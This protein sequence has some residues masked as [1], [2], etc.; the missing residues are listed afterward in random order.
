[1]KLLRLVVSDLHVGTGVG[2]GE[3]NPSEDFFWDDRFA[4]LLQYYDQI[5]GETT[6]AELMFN[7]DIFDLLKVKV[8]DAWPRDI[9]GDVA[10]EKLRR[11]LEGHP[12][13]VA[14]LRRF[15]SKGNRRIVYLPGNHDIEMWFEAPQRLFRRYV[16][17]DAREDL[18]RFITDTDTY[19]LPEG[20]QVRHGHQFESIHRMDYAHMTR[21][22]RDGSEVLD[23]PWGYLWI[24]EVVN[25]AKQERS[26]VD[27]IHPFKMFLWSGLLFDPGFAIRFMLR[28]AFHYLRHRIFAFRSWPRRLRRLPSILR[29]EIFAIG[30]YDEVA[31]RSFLKLRGVHTLII[32]HSHSPRFAALRDGKVLIN[33]GA[34]MQTIYLKLQYLGQ[35][36][37]LTYALIEYPEQDKPRARLMRW[38]GTQPICEPIPYAD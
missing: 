17:P 31:T 26:Y 22:R 14:A 15:L 11:C 36:T 23:L 29:E 16:A 30:G 10:A 8:N 34:W 20:I 9:T 13:L 3:L 19:Y 38:Y 32:G 7:G 28:T 27:R 33:T 25:P 6:D 4:E 21:K 24:L 12:Q 35:H 37:R 5:A 1:M 2:D 18:V